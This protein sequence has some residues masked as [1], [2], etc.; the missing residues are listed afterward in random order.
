L[1]AITSNRPYR[2][3]QSIE[4]ART[5]IQAWSD[6]QFDPAIVKVFLEIPEHVWQDLSHEV[7]ARDEQ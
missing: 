2:A 4:A 1:D 5:E 3:K 7:T 6:K